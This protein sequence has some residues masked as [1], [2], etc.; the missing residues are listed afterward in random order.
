[1]DIEQLLQP[2]YGFATSK[3]RPGTINESALN[4]L[5]RG[6]LRGNSKA[7]DVVYE[8]EYLAGALMTED[9]SE[10]LEYYKK[11][12]V[13]YLRLDVMLEQT[14]AAYGETV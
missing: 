5:L 7:L 8:L 4:L 12:T 2:L 3:Y 11:D 6:D 13:S 10:L 9:P 1:M 14:N